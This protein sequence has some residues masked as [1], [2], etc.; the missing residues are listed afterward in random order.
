MHAGG[1]SEQHTQ[2]Q[3]RAGLSPDFGVGGALAGVGGEIDL[4]S[5]E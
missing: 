4:F 3:E 1:L 5:M 2:P